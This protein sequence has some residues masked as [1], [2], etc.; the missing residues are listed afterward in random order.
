MELHQLE[1]LTAVVDH[2]TF[3]AAAAA[4]HVSQSGVSAQIRKLE[5][6]LGEELLDRT[7]LRVTPTH[8]GV[9]VL[10]HARAALAAVAA[11][12]E[13]IGEVTGLL[14]GRVTVGM[15]TA[16]AIPALFE[17]LQRFRAAHPDVEMRLTESGS[18]DLLAGVRDGRFDVVLTGLAGPPPADVQAVTVVDDELVLV[19]ADAGPVPG[20][21]GLADIAAGPLVTLVP[22]SGVRTAFENAC[23]AAG[24]RPVVGL[25]AGSP[26]AVLALVRRGL[27]IGVVARSM[28]GE[29]TGL[30]VSEFDG[31]AV[32]SQLVLLRRSA[33]SPAARAL[34]DAL[35]AAFTGTDTE[36]AETQQ[37]GAP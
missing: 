5:H 6:E 1:Y 37:A 15:V 20:P 26:E 27:G 29:G 10:P 31:V 16:C 11:V 24:L 34:L 33:A 35:T 19:R 4:L 13:A 7:G 23:A 9:A 22:G 30:A 3:T 17:G 8:A 28:V 21:C 32:R 14:R 25:E 12:R 36:G 18:D 2:G